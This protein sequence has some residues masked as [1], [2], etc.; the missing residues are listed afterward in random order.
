V[1]RKELDRVRSAAKRLGDCRARL[2]DAMLAA[3]RSGESVRYIAEWADM[4]PATTQRLLDEAKARR[5]E[6][7]QGG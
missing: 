1:A 5:L 7:E 2:G 3:Q 4:S 6:R